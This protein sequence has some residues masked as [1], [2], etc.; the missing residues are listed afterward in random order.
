M[1]TQ[2]LENAINRQIVNELWASNSYLMVGCFMDA[3]GLKVLAQHFFKQSDEERVHALK[4]LHYLLAVGAEPRIDA[5]PTTE[6]KYRTVE[7]AVQS[8]L[9]QEKAVTGQINDLMDLA[10]RSKDYASV[11]FLKW[12]VDEQVEEESSMSDL[13]L[14][15]KQAGPNNLLLTEERL[16]RMAPASGDVAGGRA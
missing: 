14:L 13:L 2:E 6:P 5:V 4:L 15:V 7:E 3:Q 10:H 12:F 8:A 16:L 11:S 1:P 9:D